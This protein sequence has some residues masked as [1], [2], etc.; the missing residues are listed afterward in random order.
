MKTTRQP[1]FN[2]GYKSNTEWELSDYYLDEDLDSNNILIE[3]E[4]RAY[5]V[6]QDFMFWSSLTG[7]SNFNDIGVI[8]AKS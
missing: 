5:S 7:I 6:L 1:E 2:A 3:E 8:L 4:A